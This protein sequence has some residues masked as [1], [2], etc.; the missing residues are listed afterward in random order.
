VTRTRL[1]HACSALLIFSALSGSPPANAVGESFGGYSGASSGAG[2]SA[3]PQLPA[4]LPVETPIEGT[5]SLASTS[6]ATGGRGFGRA[7]TVWPG[8]LTVGI[9]PLIEIASGQRL[10]IPDYP[11]VV[12]QKEYEDA[13]HNEQPG[14]TMATDVRDDHAVAIA[15]NGAFVIPGLVGVGS[16]RTVSE[17]VLD[18]KQI[19]STV[20]ST[21]NGIDVGVLHIDS[22]STTSTAGSDGVTATCDGVAVVSGARVGDTPVVIDDA[23]MHAKDSNAVTE[24]LLAS[25]DIQARTLGAT[26]ACSGA[27]G[28]RTTGGLLVSV[29]LPAVPP[30]PPGGRLNMVF[31][32]TTAAAAASPARTSSTGGLTNPPPTPAAVVPH[33]PGPAS[34]GVLSSNAPL[35][36]QTADIPV[37]RAPPTDPIGYSFGGVPLPLILG[38]LLAAIPGSRRIRRYM[39]RLFTEVVAT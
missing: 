13:K 33:A 10:P 19:T 36:S 2:F 21:A 35:P 1:L 11:L 8:T 27:S 18:A 20:T 39:E 23:G 32:S 17:G 29:P 22:V 16:I 15:E 9:R 6:L 26:D 38:L 3:G 30:L 34:G 5:L 7:S 4:V 31:A 37:G 25:S 28:N 14:I 12:E 24:A